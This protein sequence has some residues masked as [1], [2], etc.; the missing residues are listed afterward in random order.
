MTLSNDALKARIEEINSIIGPLEAERKL[1]G[2]LLQ[3]RS[4]EQ[5]KA[6]EP[7]GVG[8]R[9]ALEVAP[10]T[11]TAV[12]TLIEIL[13]ANSPFGPPTL[14]GGAL[15]VLKSAKGRAL[16]SEQLWEAVKALGVESK[17]A[18]PVSNLEWILDDALRSD[19]YPELRKLQPHVYA[20]VEVE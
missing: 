1:L 10:D 12:G 7:G 20:W 17:S 5:G 8:L 9:E 15:Q 13:R 18:K 6:T 19:K 11:S 4:A 14:I 2:Q 16:N 3:V